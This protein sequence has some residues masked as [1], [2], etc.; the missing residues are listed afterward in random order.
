MTATR[1]WLT[2][3][4]V[5]PA[6]SLEM[7]LVL[8]VIAAIVLM[9]FTWVGWRT[10]VAR[11]LVSVAGLGLA[12]FVGVTFRAAA[13]PLVQPLGLPD[14]ILEFASGAALAAVIYALVL[15]VSAILLKKTEQQDVSVVR[16]GYGLFGAV[17][18]LAKGLVFVWA[19]CI[20]LRLIGT[21]AAVQ[22]EL[23]DP[24]RTEEA[25]D[26]RWDGFAKLEVLD[27]GQIGALLDRVDPVPTT[28]RRSLPK[29]AR[30]MRDD[31]H[32]D[33]LHAHP[34]MRKLVNH[35]KMLALQRDPELARALAENDMRKFIANP[36]VQEVFKD[37]DLQEI[38][39]EIEL[40]KVLDQVLAKKKH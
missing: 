7:P 35:P 9:R 24:V 36:R 17:I 29:L 39:K 34:E 18:G 4:A 21:A 22:N 19:G 25:V 13:V 38:A 15:L 31:E 6:A 12:I 10:G 2:T 14:Q 26:P 8:V 30:V 3:V 1:D 20:L 37:P 40:E 23:A 28:F 27:R 5:F 32:L 11:Q 33:R 16:F